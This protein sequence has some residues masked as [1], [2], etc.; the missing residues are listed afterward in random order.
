MSEQIKRPALTLTQTGRQRGG[1]A[2]VFVHGILSSHH[3]FEP[4][5]QSF[6]QDTRFAQWS[7]GYF[8]Y[9]F[10]QAM[11]DSAAQFGEALRAQ[12]QGKGKEVTLVCH[13]MGGLV[14]RLAVI[15]AGDPMPFVKRLVMLGTPNFG[16]I[17][18]AQLGVLAQM[19]LR[20]T[21]TLWAAFTRKTGVIDL[22]RVHK[23]FAEFLKV[24]GNPANARAVEYITI[25]GLYYHDERFAWDSTGNVSSR[26]LTGLQLGA[27]WLV[28]AFPR[29]GGPR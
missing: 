19:A 15:G 13:S 22:T 6:T 28:L 4:M 16:A 17:R 18:P 3:T 7:L 20:A 1:K 12:F 25:P 14:A 24:K 23:Q 10:W 26:A 29:R 27:E 8:D 21:G 9:D 5:L 11:A 2:I